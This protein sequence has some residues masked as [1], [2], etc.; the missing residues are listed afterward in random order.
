MSEGSWEE[1]KDTYLE[2]TKRWIRAIDNGGLFSI[3][4]EVYILFYE[5]EKTISCQTHRPELA[6]G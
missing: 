6:T 2:Y 1:S 3:N 4:D 5:I